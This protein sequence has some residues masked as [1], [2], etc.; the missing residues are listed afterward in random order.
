MS[1][2]LPDYK[3][4]VETNDV[5]QVPT[6]VLALNRIDS[7]KD[8]AKRKPL[9]EAALAAIVKW[10]EQ[11]AAS[12]KKVS[13]K[14]EKDQRTQVVNGVGQIKQQLQNELTPPKAGGP[15]APPANFGK[16]PVKY[17][18]KEKDGAAGPWKKTSFA[19]GYKEVQADDFCGAIAVVVAFWH[20]D[21]A[22]DGAE[23]KELA[24]K[25]HDA[26]VKELADLDEAVKKTTDKDFKVE[27]S[28]Y[29]SGLR[30][31][32]PPLAAL[33]NWKAG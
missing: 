9:L 22:T 28:K 5:D 6:I 31:L 11:E 17:S 25:A 29:G 12:L 23:G 19:D 30:K 16:A 32:L 18:D 26:L 27:I 2:Y 24:A 14:K 33:K 4:V 13:D 21:R 1:T 8:A 10:D 15:P 20:L 3:K 7:T